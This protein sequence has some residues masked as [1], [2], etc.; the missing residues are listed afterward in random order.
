VQDELV[1]RDEPVEVVW[2]MV[3]EADVEL[4]GARAILRQDGKTLTAEILSPEEAA[5]EVIS[6]TPPPPQ[7]Q[8]EGTCKLAVRLSP[9][10]ESLRI[11]VLLTPGSSAT[12]E[13]PEVVPLDQ[14][15]TSR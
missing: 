4:E 11:A 7:D 15:T 5:F 6:T 13:A 10:G 2:G 1:L 9:H 3:T 12:Q 8:N 14:W